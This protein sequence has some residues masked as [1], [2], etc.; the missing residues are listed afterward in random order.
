VCSGAATSF[1]SGV[2]MLI[3]PWMSNLFRSVGFCCPLF[4]WCVRL[5]S[6]LFISSF[7]EALWQSPSGWVVKPSWDLRSSLNYRVAILQHFSP[8]V[9]W[10]NGRLG[11]KADCMCIA[12][13]AGF[14][15]LQVHWLSDWPVRRDALF[16]AVV[17]RLGRLGHEIHSRP[18]KF[19]HVQSLENDCII[20]L[21]L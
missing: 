11:W 3:S 6:Q 17:F 15:K 21:W 18:S 7:V 16:S 10:P 19:D 9:L 20:M 1:H 2:Y 5:R 12:S 4:G 13:L 14:Y 8:L